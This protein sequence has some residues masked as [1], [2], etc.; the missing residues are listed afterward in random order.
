LTDASDFPDFD[1]IDPDLILP[2]EVI[3]EMT[4]EELAAYLLLLN[5]NAKEWR[6]QPH[7]QAAEDLATQVDEIMFGGSAGPGKTEWLLWHCYHQC[8]KFPGLRVLMIRRTFPQLRR[9]LIERSLLR[10]DPRVCKYM[11]SEKRWKFKNGSEIEFGFCDAEEDYRHYLSA[12]ADIVAF[13][14]LTEMTLMQYQMIASRCRTT[15][16]KLAQG[17]RPHIISATNPGLAG[18]AWVRERFVYSTNYGEK[19]AELDI[20]VNGKD[21]TRKIGFMPARVTD[22]KYID[23]GYVAS[24]ASLPEHQQRLYLHGDW[25]AFEGAYFEEFD[26]EKH[27][28]EP[29]NIPKSWPRVRGIDFGVSK[30]FACV[31]MAFDH[32]GNCYVYRE[33]YET[34]LTATEQAKL[35]VA[36][37]V[38]PEVREMYG[39]DAGR[40]EN[41][42]RTVADPSVFNK[43]GAG[44]SIAQMYAAGGLVVQ[45]AMNAR[46]DGWNRVKDYLRGNDHPRLF[47]FSTCPNLV[48]EMTSAVRDDHNPE[49]LDTTLPDHLCL[50]AGTMVST[51]ACLVPIENVR[52]GDLVWTREGWRPVTHAEMTA[53]M[54][55]TLAVEMSHGETLVGT[56]DHPVWT[57][58]GLRRLGDLQV[59]DATLCDMFHAWIPS[60]STPRPSSTGASRTTSA[61]ATTSATEFASTARSGR[62]PTGRSRR[63]STSTISTTT[64]ATTPWR[65]SSCSA[66]RN[67]W[68]TTASS[69]RLLLFRLKRTL[70]RLSGIAAQRGLHGTAR[71]G[72]ACGT[73]ESVIASAPATSVAPASPRLAVWPEGSVPTPASLLGEG[74]PGSMTLSGS[75]LSAGHLSLSTATRSPLLVPARVRSISAGPRV[76]V[77]NLRVDGCHEFLANG[78]LVSNCDAL[79]YGLAARNR[80][81]RGRKKERDPRS[82]SARMDS[83]IKARGKQGHETLGA[84]W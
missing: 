44:M 14:E 71:T 16:K 4:E 48:K 49:D 23:P 62:T 29:F 6:L 84:R 67:T 13:E 12:E 54:A 42:D 43:T 8:L 77:Y 64:V 24:L 76:P 55:E 83:I 40:P 15:T 50:A 81:A 82:M 79:R 78:V 70:R 21:F 46:V 27:I 45:K 22:N 18:H 17:V 68:S 65:T 61:A 74:T 26:R 35:I 33:L 57:P 47:I 56:A 32:D 52:P 36:R 73:G 59:E 69:S 34:N 38:Y 39:K 19:I 3:D 41:F 66:P 25:D 53:A 11:P 72:S 37:S 5:E 60:S 10:F 31:W 63:A 51:A 80:A 75:A 58:S 2:S 7:Q 20:S 28:V 30:P 9:S 1:S